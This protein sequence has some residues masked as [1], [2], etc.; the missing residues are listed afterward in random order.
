MVGRI[1]FVNDRSAFWTNLL[2]TVFCSSG[3]GE[4]IKPALA[5]HRQGFWCCFWSLGSG[6]QSERLAEK[7]F[8]FLQH[9]NLNVA[10]PET[11]AF[12]FEQP[13]LHGNTV[14]F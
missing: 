1:L 9:L 3:S 13:H 12:C 5:W 2:L 11:M 8:C 10:V 14:G 7:G 4:W 6:L